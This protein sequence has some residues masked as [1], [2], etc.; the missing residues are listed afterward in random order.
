MTEKQQHKKARP[1]A[2]VKSLE[3]TELRDE[4]RGG[5][6]MRWRGWN[7][8]RTAEKESHRGRCKRQKYCTNAPEQTRSGRQLSRETAKRGSRIKIVSKC[9]VIKEKIH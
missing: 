5:Q 9:V 3:K 2:D 8:G 1:G 4:H 7:C 6:R